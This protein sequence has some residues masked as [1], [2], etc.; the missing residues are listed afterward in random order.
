MSLSKFVKISNIS[1]L[2]DA[3]YCAG[4]MVD[5][6]GFEVIDHTS[7]HYVDPATFQELTEW[8]AGV[9]FAGEFGHTSIGQIQEIMGQYQVQYIETSSLE[10]LHSLSATGKELIFRVSVSDELQIK[11]LPD[12]LIQADEHASI[13]IIEATDEVDKSSLMSS[14][15]NLRLNAKT[16][17]SYDLTPDGITNLEPFWTGIELKGSIEDKPGFKDFGEVMD[18]LEALEVD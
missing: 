11:D 8:V 9:S 4:M 1:N 6:L 2:S 10:V 12:L 5:V 14:I 15:D 16:L 18:I 13:I 3:R 17:R 7:E